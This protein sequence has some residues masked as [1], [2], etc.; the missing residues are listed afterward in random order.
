MTWLLIKD[1]SA[2]K[3]SSDETNQN[4]Q[5]G[6]DFFK[7]VLNMGEGNQFPSADL[8]NTFCL[9][10]IL[11]TTCVYDFVVLYTS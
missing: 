6:N 9:L 4:I 10:R 7:F 2:N 3:L 8:F 11:L 1:F 5:S